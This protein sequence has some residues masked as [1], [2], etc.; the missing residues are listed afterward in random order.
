VEHLPARR[1]PQLALQRRGFQ[2]S[3][4]DA[5]LLLLQLGVHPCLVAHLP[6][7]AC[8]TRSCSFCSAAPDLARPQLFVWCA[9]PCSSFQRASLLAAEFPFLWWLAPSELALTPYFPMAGAFPQPGFRPVAQLGSALCSSSPPLFVLAAGSGLLG[10]HARAEF[11]VPEFLGPLSSLLAETIEFPCCAEF[12]PARSSPSSSL[13][14]GPS[15]LHARSSLLAAE[16]P[17]RCPCRRNFL[18]RALL[19]P[20]HQ[21]PIPVF[22]SLKNSRR[23]LRPRRIRETV[24]ELWSFLFASCAHHAVVFVFLASPR[25]CSSSPS[26]IRPR[27]RASPCWSSICAIPVRLSVPPTS[28]S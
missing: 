10:R 16:S 9:R 12:T 2:R 20:D 23:A 1:A 26:P 28:I 13:R 24:V 25:V 18:G 7:P 8:R 3:F 22:S 4:A 27:R 15:F 5:T 21:P 11:H 19:C 17:A 14:R 6:A